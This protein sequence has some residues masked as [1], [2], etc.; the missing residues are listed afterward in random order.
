M[1][2]G[3]RRRGRKSVP[4]EAA[5]VPVSVRSVISS[6]RSECDRRRAAAA[7]LLHSVGRGCNATWLTRGRTIRSEVLRSFVRSFV[8]IRIRPTAS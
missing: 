1:Q 6:H 5:I 8:A 3:I 2:L 4:A 7:V